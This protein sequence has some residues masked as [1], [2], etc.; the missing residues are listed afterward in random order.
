MTIAYQVKKIKCPHC[1]WVRKISIPVDVKPAD[2]AADL[3]GMWRGMN[4]ALRT[5]A[6]DIKNK[7]ADSELNE[8]NAWIVMP[9]CPNCTNVYEYNVR[10]GEVR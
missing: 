2:V 10:S 4:E 3:A 9:E 7:L 1:G 6:E 5:V 8:A